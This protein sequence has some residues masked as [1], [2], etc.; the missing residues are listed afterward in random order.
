MSW[1]KKTLG[2]RKLVELLNQCIDFYSYHFIVLTL[3]YIIHR[4]SER[5]I[6]LNN[7]I[8]TVK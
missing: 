2:D 4:L 7:L 8:A 1:Q 6:Q 5:N 3:A